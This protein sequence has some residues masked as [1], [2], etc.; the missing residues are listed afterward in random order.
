MRFTTTPHLQINQAPVKNTPVLFPGLKMLVLYGRSLA[1]TRYKMP[2]GKSLL[3]FHLTSLLLFLLCTGGRAQTPYF[4][5]LVDYTIE[6]TLDDQA[7]ELR[8]SLELRYHNNSPDTLFEIPFHC[9]PRAYSKTTTAFAKQLLRHGDT[10]FHFASAADRG[11][12]DGLNFTVDGLPAEHRFD[13]THTDIVHLPLPQPLLPGASTIIRTP[14]RVKIPLSFSRLGRVGESYQI[15]QWYPKPAVYDHNGWHPIPYLNLGEYYSDFGTFTVRLTLPANYTVGAT[16]VLQNEAEQQRLFAKAQSDRQELAQRRAAGDLSEGYVAEPFPPSATEM[17]TLEYRADRVHDFAWFADKRFKVLHDTLQLPNRP[18]VDVWAMFNETEAGLW[19]EATDYLKRATRFYSDQIGEYPYPQVTGVMSALSVGGGMEYPMVTVIGRSADAA[20]LDEVLAHEVGHNW[21]QGIL[22]TNERDHP[23]MD[24]GLNS[25]YEQR[26]MAKYWPQRNAD[27]EV[28]GRKIEFNALGYRYTARQ[29]MDQAP[30]TTSDS[31]LKM[32]YWIGAYSKPALAM[33]ELESHVGTD[34]LNRA[35]RAYYEAWKF[36]HPGPEDFFAVM[37]EQLDFEEGP[38]FREAMMT[39]K[40]ADWRRRR[41]GVLAHYGERRPPVPAGDTHNPLDLYPRNDYRRKKPSLRLLTAQENPQQH[42]VFALPLV[43]F[44]EH[45]GPLLG[46]AFHNR[47]LEPRK[48]EW[49]VAPL[50]GFKSQELTGMLGGRY[51]LPFTTGL[52]QQ[53]MISGGWQRFSDFTLPRTDEAYQYGRTGLALRYELRHAPITETKSHLSLRY[54]G[55]NVA[56][57]GFDSLGDVSGSRVASDR[58]IRLEYQRE[59]QTALTPLAFGAAIEYKAASTANAFNANHL[60]LEGELS[61]GYQYE[62]GRFLRYRAF[63]GVFLANELRESSAT[64]ASGFSLTDNAFADYRYEGVFLG[65]NQSNFFEQQLGGPRQGGFRAPISRAFGFGTSNSYMLSVNVDAH[66]PAL[67]AY[68]P[69]GAFLDAGYY[70]DKAFS[71]DPIAGEFSWVGG[72]SL[73][74]FNG[75]VGL[76]LP[77]IADPDTQ[78][79]LEQRGGPL[80]RL[81][82]RLNLAG[83]APWRWV[84]GLLTQ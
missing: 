14:F 12:L 24:E 65:R 27:V 7:H 18:P 19:T 32:N 52:G 1:G 80:D 45:D 46:L 35:M 75:Q 30:N 6:A 41:D 61:G 77:L 76:Y 5:Q 28:A 42:Q 82:F 39:H 71:N 44:N 64:L 25:F 26:Y 20:S 74:A 49:L 62:Q 13:E 3:P 78:D 60:R 11:T 36:R 56:R 54:I 43:G 9:Y 55:L 66:F 84:D 58:F 53:L 83:F 73:T 33:Q 34:A 37:D 16:G 48:L 68:L 51:R 81:T 38:W 40:T 59:R 10:G 67:P 17:K 4:Q 47:T 63:G 22:A 8:A 69:F 57:P 72:V 15:T 2:C 29:G 79:L 70:G 31:L 23:W 21:F 50:Y